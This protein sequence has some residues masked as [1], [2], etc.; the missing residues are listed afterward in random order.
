MC[1][2]IVMC[3]IL[4]YVHK[5]VTADSAQPIGFIKTFSCFLKAAC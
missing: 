2:L 5:E 3:E 4:N 1:S